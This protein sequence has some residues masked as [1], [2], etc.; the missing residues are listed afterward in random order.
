MSMRYSGLC[1]DHYINQR[2]NLKMDLPLRRDTVLGFFDRLR[3]EHPHLDRLKRYS[4]E[5]A[6]ESSD[7]ADAP[8]QWVA[9]RKTSL[10]SGVANPGDASEALAFHRGLLDVAPYYLDINGLDVEHL[11]LLFGFDLHAQGNHDAIVFKALM[12]G[13]ALGSIVER[14]GAVP[15]ECQPVIGVCINQTAEQ[16]V[17]LEV[18]TRSSSAAALS[19]A[20]GSGPSGH[21]GEGGADSGGEAPISVYL[22][23]RRVH[24]AREIARLAE[25]VRDMGAQGLEI[26]ENVVV[27]NVLAP[28]R[29]CIM[30]A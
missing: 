11:E 28:L 27:P 24:P 5:L 7:L 8:Q 26:V 20:R 18:K 4:N 2:L 30:T 9:V 13:S 10:R 6:L 14:P 22:I 3:R 21:A 23:V 16:Q 15:V 19:G 17:F 29:S 1:T 12:A 25:V